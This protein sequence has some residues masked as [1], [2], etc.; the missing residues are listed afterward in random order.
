MYVAD[1]G[2]FDELDSNGNKQ[3]F[4][5]QKH[6]MESRLSEKRVWLSLFR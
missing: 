4:I 5:V 2:R 1:S 6:S 3:A